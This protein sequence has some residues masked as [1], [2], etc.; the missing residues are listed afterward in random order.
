MTHYVI[1]GNGVAGLRAAEVVRKRDG[2]GKIT[3]LFAGGMRPRPST[4][5]R[6]R[7]PSITD[8]KAPGNR[9][10]SAGPTWPEPT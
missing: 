10:P 8:G 1:V 4:P 5:T 6:G 2:E 7:Q 9:G 3:L